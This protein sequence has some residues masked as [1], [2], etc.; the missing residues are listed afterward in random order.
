MPAAPLVARHDF[1]ARST[2][3]LHPRHAPSP[4]TRMPVF[5][6]KF[7]SFFTSEMDIACGVVTTTAPARYGR[8]FNVP[9]LGSVPIDPAFVQLVEE[10]TRPLYPEGTVMAG[11]DVSSTVNGE[12]SRTSTHGGKEGLFVDKYRDCSLYPLFDG[13]VTRLLSDLES[14]TTS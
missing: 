13:F 11:K 9:F 5:L 12:E 10:G 6:Q 1:K 4:R 2:H 7:N 14:G 3:Y 8:D